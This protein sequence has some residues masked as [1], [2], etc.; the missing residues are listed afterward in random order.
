[1]RVRGI[2]WVGTTTT[3]YVEMTTFCRDVL[4][5]EIGF[6]EPT[7]TEFATIDG[8]AFQVMRPDNSYA[9]LFTRHAKGPVPLFEVDD[10]AA[11]RRDLEEAGVEIIGAPGLD[12]HWE[13]LNLRAP[14]GHLYELAT[15]RG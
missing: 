11:A 2:R 13:W 14:D 5:L 3:H 7:T 15:R 1:M 6:V 12:D 10:L 4:G 9:A 8:D